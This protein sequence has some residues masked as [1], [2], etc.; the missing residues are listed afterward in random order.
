M[1]AAGV[2]A[3]LLLMQA[4]AELTRAREKIDAIDTRIVDLLNQRARV[5]A[6]VGEVKRKAGLPVH[7]P[8]REAAVIRKAGEQA[9]RSGG[10]LPAAVTE[11]I[12]R[13]LVEQMR[14]WE[15]QL[16]SAPAPA[17]K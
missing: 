1:L 7:A 5:V 13:A 15:E 16:V 3:S 2:L 10:P 8:E 12:Y 9:V 17:P 14:A 4:D 6:H 11:R